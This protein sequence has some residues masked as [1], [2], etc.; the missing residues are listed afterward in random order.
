MGAGNTNVEA[1]GGGRDLL[2][3]LF[4]Y[5]K[6]SIAYITPTSIPTA[7]G[8]RIGN[9]TTSWVDIHGSNFG[10]RKTTTRMKV[11]FVKIVLIIEK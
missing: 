10:S 9:D 8:K 6:P 1:G 5:P 7:G 4:R 2:T 11:Y 3:D